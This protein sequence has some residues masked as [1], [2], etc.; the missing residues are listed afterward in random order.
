MTVVYVYST[1][2]KEAT[3]TVLTT[4]LDAL[5]P[6]NDSRSNTI[7]CAPVKS[8]E[9]NKALEESLGEVK[10]SEIPIEP[11]EH[12]NTGLGVA[13]DLS[14]LSGPGGLSL[15]EDDRL[16][17]QGKMSEESEDEEEV[18]GCRGRCCLALVLTVVAMATVSARFCYDY[19]R[20]QPVCSWRALSSI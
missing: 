4:D 13:L 2:P 10:H 6:R 17:Q 1:L 20:C 11:K 16:S 5:T 19:C 9:L 7:T 15:Q 3:E 14:G 8:D 18:I 12:D